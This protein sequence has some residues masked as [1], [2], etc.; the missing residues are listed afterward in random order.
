MTKPSIFTKVGEIINR[1]EE[2]RLDELLTEDEMRYIIQNAMECKSINIECEREVIQ[3]VS[4]RFRKFGEGELIPTGK[5]ICA[6]YVD[7]SLYRDFIVNSENDNAK[8]N[9]YITFDNDRM[10]VFEIR[11][12]G[13]Y[14]DGKPLYSVYKFNIEKDVQNGD[15]LFSKVHLDMYVNVKG[16]D[17]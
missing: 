4:E 3:G 11:D 10:P 6:I 1:L 2:L 7:G 9:E 5:T 14:L 13:I 8:K 12:G 17:I 16:L 15:K